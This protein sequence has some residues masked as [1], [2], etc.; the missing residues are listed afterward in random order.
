[1]FLRAL[2]DPE[3]LA[4]DVARPMPRQPS[5]AAS[6][7]V[8]WHAWV[9]TVFG[10]QSLWGVEDLPGSM[11]ADIS[12]DAHL[13]ELKAAFL[14]SRFA[15][16]TPVAIERSFS[17]VLGGRVINGRMD[18]VFEV[19]GRYEVVDWKTGGTATVDPRQLA[20]YRLAWAHIAGVPWAN[21]DA[22]F[23][24]VATGEEIRPDT[25]AEVRALLSLD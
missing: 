4:L 8:A 10:Q 3:Q 17:L 25:D 5:R 23:Y 21:V 24:L 9:E 11:D 14:R 13:E 6:R 16:M 1:M 2:R 7:G 20:I 22:A 12:T 15:S 18:A 19:D